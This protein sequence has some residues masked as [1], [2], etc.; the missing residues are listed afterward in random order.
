MSFC[1]F[2]TDFERR[3][4]VFNTAE[5]YVTEAANLLGATLPVPDP[6]TSNMNSAAQAMQ[7]YPQIVS[8]LA[9][10]AHEE[11]RHLDAMNTLTEIM[12]DLHNIADSMA[13]IASSV[14]K[15]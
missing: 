1:E 3:E 12:L 10:I 11:E 14:R 4:H 9:L 7:T 2:D 15:A 13:V 8:T 5:F 6:N